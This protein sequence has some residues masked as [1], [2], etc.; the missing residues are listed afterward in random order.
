MSTEIT[1]RG[2]FAAFQ[3]PERGTVHAILDFEGPAMEPVYEQVARDL[4]A[5]KASIAP[6]MAR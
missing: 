5:V 6:C 2:S 1:V 4:E 3:P